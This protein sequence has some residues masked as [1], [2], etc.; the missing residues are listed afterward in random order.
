MKR[1]PVTFNEI[2]LSKIALVVK[3]RP[4]LQGHNKSK[5]IKTLLQE[6]IAEL[7]NSGHQT[8]QET[9]YTK[10]LFCSLINSSN[11]HNAGYTL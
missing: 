1:Q 10:P 9:S 2:E 4:D 6:R 7:L 5:Q 3:K 8:I 11:I